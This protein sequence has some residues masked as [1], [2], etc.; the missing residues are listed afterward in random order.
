MLAIAFDAFRTPY[1][2]G[3]ASVIA[4]TQRPHWYL[5]RFAGEK[6]VRAR[7]LNP[8]WTTNAKRSCGLLRGFLLAME[9]PLIDDFYPDNN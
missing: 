3:R 7:F 8:D 1:I 9:R 2:E 5:V 4:K 6:G